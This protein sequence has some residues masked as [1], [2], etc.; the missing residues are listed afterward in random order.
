MDRHRARATPGPTACA[1][2]TRVLQTSVARSEGPSERTPSIGTALL[3]QPRPPRLSVP[4]PSEPIKQVCVDPGRLVP[5]VRKNGAVALVASALAPNW[6]GSVVVRSVSQVEG[7]RNLGQG[8][9]SAIQLFSDNDITLSTTDTTPTR[10][11]RRPP[12]SA[13]PCKS[14]DVPPSSE[15]HRTAHPVRRQEPILR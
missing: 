5:E 15:P 10:N 7:V 3:Q 2:I 12:P 13:A 1:Q 6:S 4:R 11:G 8:A 9:P 14:R